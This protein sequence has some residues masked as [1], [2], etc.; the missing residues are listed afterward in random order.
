MLK[1]KLEPPNGLELTSGARF[2]A[3][4]RHPPRSAGDV[5]LNDVLAGCGKTHF[6]PHF[7]PESLPEVLEKG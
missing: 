4:L 5:R 1:F 2:T 6:G 3:P 7:A